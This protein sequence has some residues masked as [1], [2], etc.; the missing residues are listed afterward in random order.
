V[1][2]KD[3]KGRP[4]GFVCFKTPLSARAAVAE[5]HGSQWNGKTLFVAQA[6]KKE[7]RSAD[8]RRQMESKKT[9][10][11][12]LV[13]GVNLYVKYLDDTIDDEKL[14]VAFSDFGTVNNAKVMMNDATG[15][16]RC[17]GFVSFAT[18]EM[19]T[20]AVTEMNGR[21]FG[22]TLKPLYVGLAETK[23]VRHAK[24]AARYAHQQVQ[25]GPMMM[26]PMGYYPMPPRVMGY[27][28]PNQMHP[29]SRWTGAPPGGPGQQRQQQYMQHPYPQHQ[30]V[31]QGQV[32]GE[33]RGPGGQRQQRRPQQQGGSPVPLGQQ[34]Q[35]IPKNGMKY[36]Q[37]A[38][39]QA[40]QDAYSEQTPNQGTGQELTAASLAHAMPRQQKQMLGERLY[41]LV[42]MHQP[43]MAGKITGMLLEMDN[44]E[45]LHFLE[46]P[47]ALRAKI[48]EAVE[49]LQLHLQEGGHL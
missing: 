13:T 37:N 3:S 21:R 7:Q 39:N 45:L 18:A 36:T 15:K 4:F 48:Q 2:M 8:L 9:E 22:P 11:Q 17:F 10:R 6:Q 33:A 30:Q 12:K 47:D 20:K 1:V 23:D 5:L 26:P 27:H 46:S 43:D 19:A 40:P 42:Q 32:R 16:S 14:R 44:T 49:A 29:R 41:P 31:V 25:G 34:Q 35:Q 28:D 38:R 24:L